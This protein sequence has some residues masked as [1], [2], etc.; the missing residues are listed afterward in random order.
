MTTDHTQ[1]APRGTGER[2]PLMERVELIV[3]LLKFSDRLFTIMSPIKAELATFTDLMIKEG[4]LALR[5]AVVTTDL[6]QTAEDIAGDLARGWGL[7]VQFGESATQVIEQRLPELVTE[8]RRAVAVISDAD[9]LPPSTLDELVG[10][11]QRMDRTM[12]GRV[13]LVLL[14]GPDLAAHLH[15]LES[16]S[17][18][19]QVY[20]LHLGTAAHEGASSDATTRE[21]L[22][23]SATETR[24]SKIRHTHS[25]AEEKDSLPGRTLLIAGLGLSLV[26]AVGMALLMRPSEPEPPK[27]T[28]V[29]VPL[30]QSR[31]VALAP[32]SETV[33]TPA[34]EPLPAPSA[35]QTPATE[36]ALPPPAAEPPMVQAPAASPAMPAENLPPTEQQEVTPEPS[37][38]V[39]KPAAPVKPAQTEAALKPAAAPQPSP[40]TTGNSHAW[41]TKQKPSHF[42]L[43]IISLKSVRDIELFTR[44]NGLKDCHSFTQTRDGQTLHTLTCGIYPTREAALQAVA[45]LPEKARAGKPYPRRIDDIRKVLKP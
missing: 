1:D 27:P 25:Q 8:P 34:V 9:R 20:A 26:L 12:G 16:L 39:T 28:Q 42:V 2:H 13:R 31:T 23:A 35:P 36:P 4:S 29:T 24:S 38:A 44:K 14:G 18:G 30:E 6:A 32:T 10:F 19:G 15:G 22:T 17:E 43:Q 41:F 5:F 7:D 3:H 45:K 40:K 37:P 21:G 11:M 33:T